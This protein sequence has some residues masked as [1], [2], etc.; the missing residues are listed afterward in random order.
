MTGKQ[1]RNLKDYEVEGHETLAR[2]GFDVVPIPTDY[3]AVA[4][5]DLWMDGQFWELKTSQ[6]S[7]RRLTTRI[8]Q[9]VKKWDNLRNTGHQLEDTPRIVVDNRFSTEKSAD[10]LRKLKAAMAVHG[11]E[12]FNDAIFIASNGSVIRLRA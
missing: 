8:N 2:L 12:L 5:I 4:S 9:C 6:G 7:G 11:A 10:A 1:R 3:G